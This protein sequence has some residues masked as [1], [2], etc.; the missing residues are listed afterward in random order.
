M[1]HGLKWGWVALSLV[2]SGATHAQEAPGWTDQGRW[3]EGSTVTIY[4]DGLTGDA[5]TSFKAGVQSWADRLSKITVRFEPGY[6]ADPSTVGVVQVR[7]VST[8]DARLHD[9]LGYTT[10]TEDA[11]TSQIENGEI[12]ID[13]QALGQSSAMKNLGAH[14]FGHVLGLDDLPSQ[15]PRSRV[16][17]PGFQ[18]TYSPDGSTVTGATPYVPPGAQDWT[19][20][21][22]RYALSPLTPPPGP[23]TD[24]PEPEAWLLA[25]TGMLVVGAW[26]RGRQ[27]GMI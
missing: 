20:L 26:G 3:G 10:L 8:G 27:R 16:M 14:E 15:D 23:V 24:A 19:L 17:D 6:A 22:Q 11:D 13:S 12:F 9:S 1:K 2:W 4:L 25:L 18:L 21:Q 7:S 5:A